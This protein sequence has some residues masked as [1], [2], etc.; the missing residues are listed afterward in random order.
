MKRHSKS[1]RHRINKDGYRQVK[2]SKDGVSVIRS[3]HILVGRAFVPGYFDGAEID[4]ID[5]NRANNCVNNLRWYTRLENVRHS[6]EVGN[7]I[8]LSDMRG[9]NNPNYGNRKLSQKYSKDVALSKEKQSRPGNING[10][11][12]PIKIIFSDGTEQKFSYIG[13]CARYLVENQLVKAKNENGLRDLIT[14]KIKSD[15]PY[16]GMKFALQ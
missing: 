1:L 6:I 5:C 7:H 12:K 11:A 8:S 2:L 3:V 4:H 14:R 15:K 10:R 9:A 13:E 16:Y